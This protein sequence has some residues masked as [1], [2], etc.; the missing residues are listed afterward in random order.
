MVVNTIV[1][2]IMVFNK[3]PKYCR[4]FPYD[5]H[6][7]CDLYLPTCM[8]VPDAHQAKVNESTATARLPYIANCLTLP[9]VRSGCAGC[10]IWLQRINTSGAVRKRFAVQHFDDF[11]N[12]V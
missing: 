8:C 2:S 10:T 5:L 11:E 12:F 1:F 3:Q 9:T 6:S 4:I 7:I